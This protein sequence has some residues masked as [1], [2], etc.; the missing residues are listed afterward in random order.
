MENK[1]EVFRIQIPFVLRFALVWTLFFSIIGI[2]IQSINAQSF[3][4]KEF[5]AENFIGWFKDF[6]TFTSRTAYSSS[7]EIFYAI[8][9][10]W[11]YFFYTGGLL[12]LIWGLLEWV[13]NFEISL[14]A[15][16]KQ[17]SIQEREIKEPIKIIEVREVSPTDY[18]STIEQW[19]EE[20]WRLLSEGKLEE[21]RLIYE[22]LRKEYNPEIDSS[23][24]LY[25]RIKDF[26]EEIIKE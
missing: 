16:D 15:R 2:T 25:N 18:H 6:G 26:Y 1:K 23:K 24:I 7:E 22:Q 17:T 14:K 12:A 9:E 8:L 3:I 20:G 11:Y 5:F 19:L 4:F 13:I 21:A 10:K